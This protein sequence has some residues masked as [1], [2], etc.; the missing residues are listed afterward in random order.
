MP[1]EHYVADE[2]I[3]DGECRVG[4]ACGTRGKD[5]ERQCVGGSLTAQVESAERGLARRLRSKSERSVG[6]VEMKRA[7][8][9]LHRKAQASDRLAGLKEAHGGDVALVTDADRIAVRKPAD[10]DRV[11]GAESLDF[12]AWQM[13]GREVEPFVRSAGDEVDSGCG[14]RAAKRE[15]VRRRK[16]A[17]NR[18]PLR[19]P[20]IDNAPA[21]VTLPVAQIVAWA[22]ATLPPAEI[23]S[24]PAPPVLVAVPP[25]KSAVPLRLAPVPARLTAPEDPT[26][27]P[28]ASWPVPPASALTVSPA[29]IVSVPLPPSP[30]VSRS[31]QISRAE[32]AAAVEPSVTVPPAAT[33]M[34][35][36]PST[37]T[38]VPLPA[39]E[40]VP[41]P[42]SPT[43]SSP[44][45][46]HWPPLSSE[47]ETIAPSATEPM[48]ASPFVVRS[49]PL[50]DLERARAAGADRGLPGRHACSCA[51]DRQ[52]AAGAESAAEFDRLGLQSRSQLND[53]R[54]GAGFADIQ[55]AG[56][57]QR[58]VAEGHFAGRTLVFAQRHRARDRH[59]PARHGQRSRAGFA[60]RC[61]AADRNLGPRVGDAQRALAARRFAEREIGRDLEI[62]A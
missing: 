14:V 26:S 37:V 40:S 52:R 38:R 27:A 33:P 60:E 24:D 18:E 45:T 23:D 36:S 1:C 53:R 11:V 30:T 39:I 28:I 17:L 31:S 7:L 41:A 12:D 62:A 29:L 5:V 3:E 22:K 57:R 2:R 58:R 42:L 44:L 19:A 61:V 56:N 47:A 10:V 55:S 8:T 6:G 20:E 16:S 54:T 34:V 9:G 49:P 35:M 21:S 15:F 43:S 46:S 13:R 50:V 4:D 51:A 32:L 59:R 48:V 25:T